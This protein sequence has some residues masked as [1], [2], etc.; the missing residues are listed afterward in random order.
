[1][2]ARAGMTLMELTFALFSLSILGLAIASLMAATGDAWQTRDDH[3]EQSQSVRAIS[4]QLTNWVRQSQRV[5]ALHSSADHADLLL[6][7]DNDQ[8]NA[9]VNLSELKLLSYERATGKLTLHTADLTDTQKLLPGVNVAFA[10]ATVSSTAFAATFRGR[11]DTAGYDM[12][13]DVNRFKATVANGPDTNQPYKYV[14]LEL[15]IAGPDRVGDQVVMVGAWARAP[16]SAVD[17]VNDLDGDATESVDVT[18][19]GP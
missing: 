1:M 16:D 18:Y 14:N 9:E 17:F 5:V 3:R 10:P 12:A 7:V 15:W 11:P 13:V 19:T 8:F 4:T 2:R 6:W